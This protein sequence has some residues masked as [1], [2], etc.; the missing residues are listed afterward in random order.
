MTPPVPVD[1]LSKLFDI[2]PRR[3]Q[4][5]V[6]EGVLPRREKGRYCSAAFGPT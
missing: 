1:A 3:I 2:S 6:A 4:Q 5:L